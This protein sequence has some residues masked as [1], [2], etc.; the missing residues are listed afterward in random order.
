[1][2]SYIGRFAPSPTGP[3]H[4]GSL[5]AA[6]GSYLDAKANS[7]LW[8]LRI[9]DIDPPREMTGAK[10]LILGQLED[11]GLYWDSIAIYQSQRLDIYQECFDQLKHNQHL[12]ACDCPRHR[13]RDLNGIYDGKC[14]DRDLNF[15]VDT[16]IRVCL[17]EKNIGWDDLILGA[18]S[19]SFD[20]LGGDFIVRRRDGLFS[21]Q[22]AVAVDDGLKGV[23]HVIRGADLL[24]STARQTYLHTLLGLVSPEYGHLPM[25]MN[26]LGQKLSKQTHAPALDSNKSRENLALSLNILGLNPPKDISEN[27]CEEI[28]AWAISHWNINSVPTNP[29]EPSN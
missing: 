1:M 3:L 22:L 15:D 16:A 29:V 24:D 7:G 18:Q 8:L 19:F 5:V 25:V 13:V 6:L 2:T 20:E 17:T 10:D 12:Y 4:L 27:S 11:H 28:L 23:T 21:Y 9:E 14:R 26:N